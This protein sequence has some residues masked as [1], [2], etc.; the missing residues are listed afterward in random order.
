MKKLYTLLLPTLLV[1]NAN[2]QIM[3]TRSDFGQVGDK[4][5]YAY[6]TTLAS[7]FSAGAAGEDKIW[8]FSTGNVSPNYFDSAIF[9]DPTTILEIHPEEAN[10]AI[11]ESNRKSYFNID[12]NNLKAVVPTDLT[13]TSYST[14]NIV[15]FPL[16]YGDESKDSST[17]K[18]QST[19]ADLGL[20]G[21]PFSLFDSIRAEVNVHVTS[22]VDGWGVL[23]TT[24]DSA[25]VL[26]VKN[27]VNIAVK[28][29]GKDKIFGAW[30][31]IESFNQNENAYAWYGKDR[32]YALAQAALDTSG[33]VSSFQYQ[34]TEVVDIPTTGLNTV[35]KSVASSIQPNPANEEL[36]ITFTSN[37]N[38]KGTLVILDI[39]GKV[40]A[41]QPINIVKDQNDIVIKTIDLNNGIYFS[42]IVSEH[43]NTT[44]KFVV[45]H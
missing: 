12:T 29:E 26:R 41:N 34:V 2:A 7:N 25:E 4:V 9:V 24:A 16:N 10:L 14:L 22:T 38:E 17:T 36:H 39:T 21:F 11:V 28:V 8:D 45:R 33:T 40:I 1:W 44:S 35:A 31:N 5:L 13:G 43:V 19:P 23:K 37:Y 20:S 30:S 6:D 3:I 42:R 18:I 27:L 15:S 32:K